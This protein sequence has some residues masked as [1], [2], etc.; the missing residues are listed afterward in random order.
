MYCHDLEVM[1]SNPSRVELGVRSRPKSYLNQIYE[2]SPL[3]IQ[4]YV[5]LLWFQTHSMKFLLALLILCQRLALGV[6]T[7]RDEAMSCLEARIRC[8]G[9]QGCRTLLDAIPQL[10]DKEGMVK[11]F[12]INCILALNTKPPYV[13]QTLTHVILTFLL[14]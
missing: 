5:F 10:C 3:M 12:D 9:D 4:M 7:Y 1:S 11:V 6:Y 14:I 13:H 2:M 8:L